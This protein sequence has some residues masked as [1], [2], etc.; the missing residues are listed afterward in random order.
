MLISA[1]PHPDRD[2][3]AGDRAERADRQWQP[4]CQKPPTRIPPSRTINARHAALGFDGRRRATYPSTSH[5]A[6]GQ[7]LDHD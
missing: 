5:A 2:R 6:N 1:A 3:R 4:G 7:P